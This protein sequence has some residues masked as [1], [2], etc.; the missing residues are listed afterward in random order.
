MINEVCLC[1]YI[2]HKKIA[3]ALYRK[4]L[5]N[6]YADIESISTITQGTL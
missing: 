1:R 5:E 3:K 4:L 2:Y 6:F